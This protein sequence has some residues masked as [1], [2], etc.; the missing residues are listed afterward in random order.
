M[1][2]LIAIDSNYFTYIKATKIVK[3]ID[4][5]LVKFRRLEVFFYLFSESAEKSLY[6]SINMQVP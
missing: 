3:L 1:H 4:T 2:L 6:K 5:L